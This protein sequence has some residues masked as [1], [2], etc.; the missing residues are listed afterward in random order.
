MENSYTGTTSNENGYYELA[1]PK[2]RNFQ[3]C[4]S[5]FRL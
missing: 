1:V 5:V 2:K 3:G 4:I